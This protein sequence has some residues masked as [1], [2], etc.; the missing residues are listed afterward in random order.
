[1]TSF[2]KIGELNGTRIIKLH[3]SEVIKVNIKYD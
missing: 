1:M 2:L 3:I